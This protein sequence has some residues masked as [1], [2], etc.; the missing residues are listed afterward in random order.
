M[1]RISNTHSI[2]PPQEPHILQLI[3]LQILRKVREYKL[4][5]VSSSIKRFW[6]IVVFLFLLLL[7]NEV[8]QP[9]DKKNVDFLFDKVDWGCQGTGRDLMIE[10]TENLAAGFLGLRVRDFRGFLLR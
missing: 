1:H 5:Q 9:D 4:I 3:Q 10:L 7:L 6:V 2:L 8:L